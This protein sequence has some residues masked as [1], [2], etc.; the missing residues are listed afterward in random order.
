MNLV[1]LHVY[2]VIDRLDAAGYQAWL[3]GGCVRDLAL[4]RT[5]YDFDIATSARPEQVM[6][7]FE[8]TI[9]TGLS[10]GT[11]TV[12]ID[13]H[14][15]EVTTFR[16]EGHYTDS[17]RPDFVAF[18]TDL[19]LDLSRRDFTINSMAFHPQKGLMDP[20]NGWQDLID[21]RLR[22]VGDA[23]IRFREDALRMLRALRLTL[24]YDLV[25]EPH[26]I[27]AIAAERE[28]AKRLS[29]ERITHELKRMITSPHGSNVLYFTDSQILA[30]IAQ[31]LLGLPADNQKLTQLLSQWITPSWHADQAIPLFYLAAR[32]STLEPLDDALNVSHLRRMLTPKS[33]KNLARH[34]QY[35]CRMSKLA[36]RHGHAA[37]F[38][39]SLRLWQPLDQ[40]YTSLELARV[41]RV[42]DRKF[43]LGPDGA[44]RCLADGLSI[45][46]KLFPNSQG[47]MH[48]LMNVRQQIQLEWDTQGAYEWPITL[49]DLAI[50]GRDLSFSSHANDHR[51][52]VRLER[53]LSLVQVHPTENS[54]ESLRK[55]V[56]DE[57]FF[58]V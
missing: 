16:S 44:R 53:L 39:T 28:R 40:A 22:T 31:I 30:V 33:L 8:Q 24:N 1:P 38:V 18:E 7:I 17:R 35:D 43:A 41:L 56:L 21:H 29:V 55:H 51:L 15:I 57:D 3:V 20:F 14:P 26:L 13:H 23:T 48:D 25:P 54:L 11:V 50:D 9:A 32:L 12:I 27:K 36:A 19:Y 37:L 45:L 4:G 42:L 5:P 46:V 34:F 47:V 49:K 6:G 58:G 2:D 52:G 10:H